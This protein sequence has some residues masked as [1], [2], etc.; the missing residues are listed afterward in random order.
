MHRLSITSAAALCTVAFAHVASAADLS[1]KAP[2]YTPP[3]A[4]QYSWTGF[5]VGGNVGYSWGRSSGGVALNGASIYSGDVNVDG[6]IGGG[7]IG[8]NWQTGNFV[9][10]LETDIQGSGQSGNSL[11]SYGIPVVGGPVIPVSDADTY[12][13]TYF[14]TV[15]GRLGYAVD[16]WLPYVTGGWVYGRETIDGTRTQGGFVNPFSISN[17]PNGWA[18]GGGVEMAI[19]K[20][21]SVKAEY[22]YLDLGTWNTAGTAPQGI[23]TSTNKFTDNIFRVGANYR[24]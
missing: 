24:F 12:K 16:R 5:Y 11:Q 6:V 23:I 17:N 15:R 3:V 10:G 8:Y 4:L 1:T 14:G 13:L 9:I 21:W 19:D 7:Q 22:L 20:N 18:L 2:L